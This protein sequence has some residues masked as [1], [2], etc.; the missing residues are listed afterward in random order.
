M[1]ILFHNMVSLQDYWLSSTNHK[2]LISR[3]YACLLID[4]RDYSL[5][6]NK[7]AYAD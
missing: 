7:S 3:P 1:Q 4:S 2:T 5:I 6:R